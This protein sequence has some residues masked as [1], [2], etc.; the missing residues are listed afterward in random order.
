MRANG[1]TTQDNGALWLGRQV[2]IVLLG[3][4]V[5]FG[6]RGFTAGQPSVATAHALDLVGAERELGLD[7]EQTVQQAIVGH[8]KLTDLANWIYIWGHWP[9]ITVVLVWLALQHRESYLRLRNAMMIS[10]GIGL[11]LYA[12]Y[13]VAPPR[14]AELGLVDTVTEQSHAY[15][16]LQPPGFVNQYAALPSLHVG[17]DLLVGLTVAATASSVWVRMLGRLMPLLMAWAVVATANHYVIDAIAGAA[18]ALF[19]LYVAVR[20]ER[21]RAE[22]PATAVHIPR[23]RQHSHSL[24]NRT[25]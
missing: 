19:G 16:V 1:H 4:V 15:R 9:V 10:G 6:V 24:L 5:Y 25:G 11:V 7:H 13:P 21:H 17:W 12:S 8:D 2:G 3:V 20:L 23:Q 22:P 18:L 14:L